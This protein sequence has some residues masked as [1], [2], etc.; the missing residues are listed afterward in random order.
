MALA[1]PL[2]RTFTY[3]VPEGIALPI[4][5]GTRVLVPF[6]NRPEIGICLGATEPPDGITLKPIQE[7]F[8]DVPS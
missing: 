4:A 2:F 8:S 7:V 6:R 3:R 1:A 5:P